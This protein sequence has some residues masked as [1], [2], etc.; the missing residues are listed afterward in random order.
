MAP[1][2]EWNI[3]GKSE[4]FILKVK[5]SP[6]LWWLDD[7]VIASLKLQL[8][9]GVLSLQ[10]SVSIKIGLQKEQWWSSDRVMD[11]QGSLMHNW[12]EG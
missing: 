8:L 3:L 7:W 11:G 1:V 2:S 5:L 9:R 10:L 12:S 6:K 4:H